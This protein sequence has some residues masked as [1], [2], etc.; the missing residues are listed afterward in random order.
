MYHWTHWASYYDHFFQAMLTVIRASFA[1]FPDPMIHGV[2]VAGEGKNPV[3]DNHKE[4]AIFYVILVFV[5]SWIIV[6]LFIGAV[7]NTFTKVSNDKIPKYRIL[8]DKQR[9]WLQLQRV[10]SG[11]NIVP[12]IPPKNFFLFVIFLFFIFFLEEISKIFLIILLFFFYFSNKYLY[13]IFSSKIFNVMI[14]VLISYDAIIQCTYHYRQPWTWFLLQ[15]LSQS[16][17]IY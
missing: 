6:G 10:I 1:N 12:K 13:E 9:E 15:C 4:N 5:C 17:Q 11:L 2:D 8:T 7:F 3:R 14:L 16:S